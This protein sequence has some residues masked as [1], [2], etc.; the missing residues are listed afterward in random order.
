MQKRDVWFEMDLKL[1]GNSMR[2][3]TA[4]LMT[5][6]FKTAHINIVCYTS[7]TETWTDLCEDH[8]ISVIIPYSVSTTQ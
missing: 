8:I 4:L 6:F 7:K 5:Q 3:V 1:K 2:R